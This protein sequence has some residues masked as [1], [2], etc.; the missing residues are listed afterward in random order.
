[1][2][3]YLPPDPYKLLGVA[4]DAKLAEIRSA[5]RKSVLKCH[6]DKVQDAALKAVKQDEFQKVQQAYE[7]LSDD[8][9]RQQ[10]D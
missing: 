8:A 7:L 10:Y 2:N 5:H 1:M 9:K 6:P 3:S 4:R